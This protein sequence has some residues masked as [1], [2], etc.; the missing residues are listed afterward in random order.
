MN[1]PAELKY[2][3]SHEWI[4]MIDDTTALIGITDF[5]QKE[6]GDLV[7]INLPEEGDTITVKTVF[8]DIESVK[9]VS[10]VI[11]PVTGTVLAV[12]EDLADAPERLNKDP[13]GA[14]IVKVGDITEFEDPLLSA[15]EY[16]ATTKK[17]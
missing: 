13:Y 11:S 8:S 14:W 15:S 10:D 7:F 9:A 6:M 4:K 5:A 3:K 12:N 17:K 16:E 1:F 2:S